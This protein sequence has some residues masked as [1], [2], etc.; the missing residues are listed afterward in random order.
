M[1]DKTKASDFKNLRGGDYDHIKG[2]GI[3]SDPKNDPTYP[4]KNRTD[5][6]QLGYSWERPEQQP[7]TVEI[8]KTVE[9]PNLTSV[10]GTPNPPSGL[11]GMIRRQAFKYS[12]SSYGHWLPLILAD[13]V[14]M[15]EGLIEDLRHGVVPNVF[16][17]FGWQ[18]EWKHNRK[19]FLLKVGISTAV[20]TGVA[21]LLLSQKRK[22]NPHIKFKA[23]GSMNE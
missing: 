17:E 15:V 21:A 6:E 20:V 18:S 19:N 23:A 12:E 5:E 3:D 2:W 4:M 13:R 22:S 14:N 10:F 9:R 1:T 8:L 7:E 16:S 11:S